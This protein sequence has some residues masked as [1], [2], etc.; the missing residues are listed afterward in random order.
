MDFKRGDVKT[1][2]Q[3]M[4]I[5]QMEISAGESVQKN[6]SMQSRALNCGYIDAYGFYPQPL[7]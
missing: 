6:E 5:K 2:F 7:R 1:G 4:K 3:G